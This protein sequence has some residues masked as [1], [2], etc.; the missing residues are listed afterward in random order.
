[1]AAAFSAFV[2][3]SDPAPALALYVNFNDVEDDNGFA[4]YLATECTDARWPSRYS[5]WRRDAI[6]VSRDA[7]FLTW[8]NTWFNA[9][10][11]TW[12]ARSGHPVHVRDRGAPPILLV[13]ETLDAATPFSGSLEVRRRFRHSVLI[14]TDGGTTHANSLFG[15]NTCVDDR[16]ADYLRDGTL[17]DRVRGRR[18]DV[19]CPA[20]P[21]PE[22]AAAAALA[23]A[24][25]SSA[26]AVLTEMRVGMLAR[27]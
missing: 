19:V 8:D 13:G 24:S 4:M 5:Q 2:N 1:V 25:G 3:D 14:A 23:A 12:P 10:C 26:R 17:P 15:G 20:L 11:L 6:K 18:A 27:F 21:E 22:P 9:P 7:P 16:I